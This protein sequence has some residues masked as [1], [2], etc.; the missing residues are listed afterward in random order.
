MLLTGK[1]DI[2]EFMMYIEELQR[3]VVNSL[4]QLSQ[5]IKKIFRSVFLCLHFFHEWRALKKYHFLCPEILNSLDK[6]RKFFDVN[7]MFSI[8]KWLR[9]TDLTCQFFTQFLFNWISV[10]MNNRSRTCNFWGLMLQI[11]T[12]RLLFQ[13]FTEDTILSWEIVSC[14]FF[15]SFFPLLQINCLKKHV[16]SLFF[17]YRGQSPR[18]VSLL[19][20]HLNVTRFVLGLLQ[21]ICN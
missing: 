1:W 6:N 19:T 2:R 5:F 9:V 3:F 7:R 20:L 8:C 10:S 18:K 14:S 15:D 21:G 12:I 4:L 11:Q 17:V 16:P 13:F